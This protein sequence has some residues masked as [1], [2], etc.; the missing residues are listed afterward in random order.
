MLYTRNDMYSSICG[1]W[2]N[3]TDS[4]LCHEKW[5]HTTVDNCLIAFMNIYESL[6]T[7]GM[8]FDQVL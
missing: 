8:I 6:Q 7:Q 4:M 1:L 3:P 5:F 2:K